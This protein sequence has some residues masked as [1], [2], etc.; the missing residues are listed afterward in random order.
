M[1]CWSTQLEMYCDGQIKTSESIPI[2]RG[3]FQGDS[4]SP[5][6]FC[7]S[8]NP[9]SFLLNREEGYHPG[10]PKHRSP[11]PLT[12]L[13]YMD[14]IELLAKGESNLKDQILLVESFSNDIGMTFGLTNVT[15]LHLK[16]GKQMTMDQCC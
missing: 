13:L 6:L 12:H 15:F 5:L 16:R 2:N 14:D 3:I 10:P 1:S 9:L 4:F 11:T 8:L 7:L